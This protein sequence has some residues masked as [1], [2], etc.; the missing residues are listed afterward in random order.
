M[1]TRDLEALAHVDLDTE[2]R[3]VD[4][5]A[6]AFTE[7]DHAFASL[8]P[9]GRLGTFVVA[10]L[11][12]TLE[13]QRRLAA[14]RA[15]SEPRRYFR[16]ADWF[17]RY[18]VEFANR[19]RIALAGYRANPQKPAIAEPWRIAFDAATQRQ[20]VVLEDLLL[21]INA[22][23]NNDQPMSLAKVGVEPAEMRLADH[24]AVNDALAATTDPVQKHLSE[25]YGSY[26]DLLDR[27]GG[28]FDEQLSNFALQ[29]ARQHSWESG[30]GLA[31]GTKTPAEVE[32][33]AAALAR[34]VLNINH[35]APAAISLL[36]WLESVWVRSGV[37]GQKPDS[38]AATAV[39]PAA[40]GPAGA[41][42]AAPIRELAATI[43]DLDREGNRLAVYA[44]VYRATL[45]ELQQ[46]FARREIENRNWAASLQRQCAHLY[47]N[48]LRAYRAHTLD[49]VP[50]SWLISFEA[51][52]ERDDVVAPQL[53]ALG[54]NAHLVHDMAIALF[55]EG[56]Y[57]RNPDR[58]STD[59]ARLVKIIADC[60]DSALA[61]TAMRY[62]R[63]L[64]AI[65]VDEALKALLSG[66]EPMESAAAAWKNAEKFAA[67]RH[68]G[69]V[70]EQ[71]RKLDAE[72]S[73]RAQQMLLPPLLHRDWRLGALRE[74]EKAGGAPWSAWTT[75][76]PTV[77][78][79]VLG[80]EIN[81]L[82]PGLRV[83]LGQ[84]D[85]RRA[86]GTTS[87]EDGNTLLPRLLAKGLRLAGASGQI[88][89]RL[90]VVT[91]GGREHWMQVLGR[92]VLITQHSADGDNLAVD[93]GPWRFT[94]A[95]VEEDGALH[96]RQVGAALLRAPV[97]T[98]IAP[99][100]E[101]EAQACDGAIQ[102]R[103][104]LGFRWLGEVLRYGGR[105]VPQ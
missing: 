11:F 101:V 88:D 85:E 87:L 43:D 56:F 9:P 40:A 102:V 39:A 2:Y 53:A 15:G 17:E 55:R 36:Q 93:Y 12:I 66:F 16:D 1:S 31:A 100:V 86:A 89:T 25:R 22:H 79:E 26:I 35:T 72:T 58:Y 33:E 99:Q 62:R 27:M 82:A 60:V 38:A 20:T 95:L 4:D 46:A 42:L 78:R 81:R 57:R 23:I 104:S 21:G 91:A 103:V 51:A 34:L 75:P 92:W 24:T 97:P 8:T 14:D 94:F 67:V 41:S 52:T 96:F 44:A 69:T 10:Y 18:L 5:V 70:R 50:A 64:R 45:V 76:V 105:L 32:R 73:R 84:A 98:V 80:A 48:A 65:D 37:D 49:L 59:Y 47:L 61:S 63:S 71:F 19:Y 6:R 90:K 54:I 3:T 77:Y 13:L 68:R 83:F 30:V 74:A 29:R 7:L 28:A